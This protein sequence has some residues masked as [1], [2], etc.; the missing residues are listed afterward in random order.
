M[1]VGRNRVS[2]ILKRWIS[3]QAAS[4]SSKPLLTIEQCVYGNEP[5][6]PP[7]KLIYE[8]VDGK[9]IE[10]GRYQ[11]FQHLLKRDGIRP[12]QIFTDPV[13]T[14]A[15]GTD[16]SFYRMIPK[17]VV[18]AETE[19]DIKI[20]LRH[21]QKCETPV[22]FR[23]AGTSL[24]GQAVTDSVLVK[25]S[26]TGKNWR[27]YEIS[28]DA[29]TVK[30]GPGLIG[31]EV[32]RLLQRHCKERNL[33][34]M[35]LG[36]DPAS[37]DSCM[38]GGIVN[39]NSSG[40]CCGVDRNTYNTIK[41]LRVILAD[42]TTLD[43]SCE[44][45]VMSFRATHR[46][47]LSG[48]AAIRDTVDDN[49]SL[50]Q[51]I[52]RK[53]KI[54]CTTGYAI[55]SFI[56]HTD[57]IE[58][59]KH[60]IVG[61]E[62]TLA[63][64]S[65]ATYFTVPEYPQKA[66]AFLMFDSQYAACKIA[67]IL[68]VNKSAV[69]AAELFDRASLRE[70]EKSD[71]FKKLVPTVVGCGPKCAGILLEVRSKTSDELQQDIA[72]ITDMLLREGAETLDGK[73]VF[74][75]EKED[76][77]ALW[78]MRRGLIPK[79]GGSRRVGTSV[80]IEDVACPIENLADM[81]IDLLDMFETQGYHDA[82][83][84][85]HALDGNLH[86]LFSQGFS[87]QSELDQ[88]NNMMD[89][90]ADIVAVRYKGSLKAEH[91]TGR[92]VASFVELEWGSAAYSIMWGLKDL[93]DPKMLLNPGVLLCE[94]KTVHSKNLKVMPIASSLIDSCIECGFC[95]SNCPSKD[96]TLTPRQRI[97]TYREL[98][99]LYASGSK[100]K[101]RAAEFFRSYA[102]IAERTCAAD[103]MCEEKC[104]VSINTGKLMKEVRMSEIEINGNAEK[105]T[106]FMAKNFTLTS[107]SMR[108]MLAT[109]KVAGSVIG[110]KNVSR[111]SKFAVKITGL[112]GTVPQYSPYLPGAAK[113][114]RIPEASTESGS[115]PREV[116]FIP[117]CVCRI[118]NTDAPRALTEI[119]KRAGYTIKV[120]P[121]SSSMCCGMMFGSKG[122]V[123]AADFCEEKLIMSLK[124]F[125]QDGKIPIVCENSPC[126]KQLGDS[127]RLVG[128]EVYDPV[129]FIYHN[130]RRLQWNVTKDAIA[131]H[132]PCSSK[133]SKNSASFEHLASL[134]AT[135]VVDSQIPCCGTAGDRGLRYPE[136]PSSAISHLNEAAV[137]LPSYSTSTTCEMGLSTH[138]STQW[139]SFIT[140]VEE[141]TRPLSASSA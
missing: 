33:M 29:T 125:S 58:I 106:L 51:T 26:H 14:F 95:E 11:Q 27:Q 13:R 46:Q 4:P 67:T 103:G 76:Y 19:N 123:K 137:G 89:S 133:K 84:F 132:V 54:K 97:A 92:N 3:T 102:D 60:L 50:K 5:S 124:S 7:G 138:T 8:N 116:I 82:C 109:A 12:S 16:A 17:I 37:I 110:K 98:A 74:H 101:I 23:A 94:D 6:Q 80:L 134:C 119:M 48:I 130:R 28:E 49:P 40:M 1:K 83:I 61:S 62:G 42:G 100:N 69:S 73:I 72:H 105:I 53:F 75:A 63:F 104:P 111:L 113:N 120:L 126:A 39:N 52:E 18:K 70:G 30:V 135:T 141:S 114:I 127:G 64:V 131:I 32:N 10:D 118:M 79:V 139:A 57:P 35:K 34:Q 78:D 56:D 121:N 129:S 108:A 88:Y 24:S 41:D 2:G 55:N 96:I 81:T 112:T 65:S 25:I 22:T 91:G 43:T 9:R 117:S 90:L 99:R 36:P 87:T 38:I 71:K 68:K 115:E 77:E 15:Y 20:I 140:L 59:L 107:A 122:F 86:L 21:A 128:I 66:S 93:F 44:D 47:L 31:G 85:G 45:S 136:L